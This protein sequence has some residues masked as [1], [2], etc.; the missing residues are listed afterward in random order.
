M[1]ANLLL[2]LVISAG[3]AFA[4]VE[5]GNGGDDM[6]IGYKLA[7]E[8][9]SDRVLSLKSC[10][11]AHGTPSDVK[12][13]LL[14]NRVEFAEDIRLSAEN[15][16][17]VSE[18]RPTCAYTYRQRN[19]ETTYSF[20]RCLQT[21][22]T[23]TKAEKIVVHESVHHFG[24]ADED[25]PDR[26]AQAVVS[27]KFRLSC[28][29][30]APEADKIILKSGR[31]HTCAIYQNKVYC[32]G[33]SSGLENVSPDSFTLARDLAVTPEGTC[34]LDDDTVRC[35]PDNQ[36]S[37]TITNVPSHSQVEA[38]FGGYGFVCLVD[39]AGSKCW[40]GRTTHYL[41]A[42]VDPLS[43][44]GTTFSG[45]VLEQNR[46]LKNV[47][48]GN[49]LISAG[50]YIN[51]RAIAAAQSHFCVLEDRGIACRGDNQPVVSGIDFPTAIAVGESHGC[52]IDG[53]NI[54]CWGT[55]GYGQAPSSVS[56][57]NPYSVS[58]GDRFSCGAD[59]HGVYCWGDPAYTN[60]PQALKF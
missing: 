34:V 4:Q 35:Y 44:A 12:K 60:V 8:T 52:A 43:F 22:N 30:T 56:F 2:L 46:V 47:P 15:H 33:D 13:W 3:S 17:W 11:F 54:R 26:V 10:S 45:Y 25:F 14:D 6:R 38:L 31:D 5:V 21:G 59:A 49:Q 32:W 51:P 50:S 7:A 57:E 18:D 37:H 24:F 20:T 41:D 53:Q 36:P 40:G 42:A 19:A 27:A 29:G 55:N 1:I 58:A 28:P 39:R 9:M 48:S 23:R 16:K